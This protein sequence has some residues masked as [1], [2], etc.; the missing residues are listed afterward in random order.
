[1]CNSIRSGVT[2]AIDPCTLKQTRV[3]GDA[4]LRGRGE[5]TLVAS[6]E[7]IFASEYTVAI[8]LT[9]STLAITAYTR[10]LAF[11]RSRLSSTIRGPWNALHRLQRSTT[12][13]SVNGKSRRAVAIART[14]DA[15]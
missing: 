15:D 9:M 5:P 3:R 14:V 11:S 2:G 10:L 12:G 4:R 13:D 1:M 7:Y 8:A 6:H